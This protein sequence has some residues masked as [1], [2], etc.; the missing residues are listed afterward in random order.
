MPTINPSVTMDLPTFTYRQFLKSTG[1]MARC[2]I[3]VRN[4]LIRSMND[5]ECSMD[6]H[7]RTLKLPL[8]HALPYYLKSFPYYDRLPGRLSDFIHRNYGFLK[9]IDVGANIGDTI[10]A[11]YKDQ[12]DKFLAIEPNPKFY[13]YLQKNF[14]E[15]ENIKIL[16][17][18]C[19]SSSTA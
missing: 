15:K 14:G 1:A 8:S 13:K 19:S 12:N 6:I 5:P 10:A 18:F 4:L 2:C 16:D 3:Y 9:C 17:F 7:G 11:F